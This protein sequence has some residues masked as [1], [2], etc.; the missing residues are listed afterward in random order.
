MPLSY[1]RNHYSLV[2]IHMVSDNKTVDAMREAILEAMSEKGPTGLVM[3]IVSDEGVIWT[4][5]FGHLDRTKKT[6]VDTETLFA[7]QSTSKMVNALAFM[8]AV[9]EGIIDLDDKLVKYFPEFRV[10]SRWGAEE[11]KNITF[12]HLLSHQSGLPQMTRKGSVFDDSPHTFEEHILSIIDT[13]LE[14]PVGSKYSYSNIGMDIVSYSIEK[15]S[16]MSFPEFVNERLAQPLGITITYGSI[17]AKKNPNRAIGYEHPEIPIEIGTALAY[18]CGGAWMNISDLAVLAQFLLNKGRHSGEQV[19]RE[20]L[21]DEM[22]ITQFD[23]DEGYTYGLGTSI[24]QGGNV[25]IVEHAGGGFGYAGL[26]AIAPDHGVGIVIEMNME[27]V[28]LSYKLVLQALDLVLGENGIERTTPSKDDFIV[29][30]K[31]DVPE[32]KLS[33]LKGQYTGVWGG[34]KVKVNDGKLV[35]AV[36]GTDQEFT[37]Y[38]EHI[39]TT[40][41]PQQIARFVM[42]EKDEDSP[43]KL[44]LLAGILGAVDLFY[45]GPLAA[46]QGSVT[47]KREWESLTGL[48]RARYY[49]VHMFYTAVKV[50]D[51]KLVYSDWSGPVPLYPLEDE[52]MIFL[53]SAGVHYEF[54]DA[55]LR[56]SNRLATKVDDPVND[57]KKAMKRSTPTSM[58]TDWVMDQEIRLLEFLERSDEVK[59]IR[60][61]RSEIHGKPD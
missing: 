8:F 47:T 50:L 43:F 21:L 5:A 53:T 32:S 24:F 10:K 6:K 58:L 18:G 16:G 14:H 4:E 40:E 45:R 48:Y 35:I 33:R 59:E 7:I 1:E 41:G 11:G 15:A 30:P 61:M 23:G 29:G 38:N 54:E 60:R 44:T 34:V 51:G 2:V 49:G 9:Q 13:W 55:G 17:E 37:P 52:P 27:N 31:Q 22:M 20:D 42:E 19:L 12:R 26:L 46:E 28:N 56:F 3:T 57:V 36:G 39:F 25:R